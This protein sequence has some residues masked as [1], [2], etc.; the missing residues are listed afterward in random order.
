MVLAL[1]IIMG[2]CGKKGDKT[3]AIV[4]GDKITQ[5]DF[6]T[7]FPVRNYS[8]TSAQDEFDKKKDFLDSMVIT[9][10]LIQAAYEKNIDQSEELARVALLNENDFIL[11]ALF[12]KH[13]RDKSK[14][15]EAETR[16]FYNHLEYKIRAAHILVDN[17]DTA[18]ALL[19][20]LKDGEN[21]ELLAYEYSLDEASRKKK[22]D[23]GY[24][25][26][27]AMLDEFQEAAFKLEVGEVSTPVKTPVGYHLIKVIDKIPNTQ[28]G[29]YETMK[30][31]I[32]EQLTRRKEATLGRKYMDS[33]KDKYPIKVDTVT[34]N[35]LLRKREMVYPPM[36]LATL[37]RNDF[38]TEH[39]DRDERELPI[40]T[41]DGGQ[42]TVMEYITKSREF[43]PERKP[44]FD[45]YDSL[46]SFIFTIK[47]RD[48]LIV[49]ARREGIDKSDAFLE[50]MK[51]FKE[52]NMA[53]FMRNDSIPMPTPP[54]ENMT[55][56]YYDDNPDEFTN[57]AK[58]HA[59]EIL[60][61]DELM[62]A[63]FKKEIKSLKDFKE[64]ASE[65]TERPGKRS[66]R[67][68][69]GYIEETW[70]PEIFP[71]AYKTAIG[72]IGG[73]VATM[74]KYSIF[75]V[76]D[77]TDPA[78]KDYLGVKRQIYD[79]LDNEQK[80][81]AFGKWVDE[82]KKITSIDIYEDALWET[83]D[84]KNYTEIDTTGN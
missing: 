81:E 4:G 3:L 15:T 48:I 6:N 67:G 68:D 40:A 47:S 10:L 21:F 39:L 32:T 1:L 72:A 43:P 71:V 46:A 70:F 29:E 14:P 82:R 20:R 52:L 16:D 74:G 33:L 69:L 55:H 42:L 12:Q 26:W 22:G 62:A 65:L 25:F 53:D 19:E 77:K 17:P 31:F 56:R 44:D 2:G 80:T 59:F 7:R 83:I 61:S 9:Q 23:L 8:F 54:D 28:R 78:L 35:Y 18:L 51:L 79:K 30:G 73:P 66:A 13:V 34:C 5:D 41:W 60:L 45:K 50:R 49:E 58:V 84:K 76:I 37:P 75:Y 38:D 64:K 11:Y 63:K 27:G 57:P 36:L 24:F